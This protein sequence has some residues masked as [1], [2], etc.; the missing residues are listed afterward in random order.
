MKKLFNIILSL[1]TICYFVFYIWALIKG[2]PPLAE[3]GKFVISYGAIILLS[4]FAFNNLLAKA[5]SVFLILFVVV[6]ILLIILFV[7]PSLIT[8]LFS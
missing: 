1:A 5:M 3:F 8:G 2:V 4:L 6:L 7:N